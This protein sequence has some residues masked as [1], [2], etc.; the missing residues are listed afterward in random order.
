MRTLPSLLLVI[1]T[2]VTVPVLAADPP[3][4]PR[5]RGEAK[6]AFSADGLAPVK[7]RGLD[8]AF[9]RPG[10]DLSQYKRVLLRPVEVSLRRDWARSGTSGRTR[11]RPEDVELIRSRVSTYVREEFEKEL[12]GAGIELAQAPAD[13]VLEIVVSVKDL[14]AVAPELQ[15]AGQ[16][17]VYQSDVYA[18]S[19]GEMTLVGE[20]R[21]SV[22]GEAE[23]RFYD[24]EQGDNRTMRPRRMN[25]NENEVEARSIARNWAQLMRAAVQAARASP[26]Q[27]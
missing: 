10:A 11:A 4:Q 3:S 24:N 23:F 16:K 13:D 5:S 15:R 7:V 27:E 19:A 9:Q 21:D 20:L 26:V 17:D 14:F 8:V 25:W 18:V 2:L 12:A 22:S 1:S 6:D